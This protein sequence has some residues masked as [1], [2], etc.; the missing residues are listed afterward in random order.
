L[1]VGDREG[2]GLKRV[3][4]TIEKKKTAV[5]VRT[6]KKVAPSNFSSKIIRNSY[7]HSECNGTKNA[8]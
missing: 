8:L 5:C 4:R 1:E 2:H 6:E 3:R 7:V